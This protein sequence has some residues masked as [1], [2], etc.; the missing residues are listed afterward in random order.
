MEDQ[1]KLR[2][3]IAEQVYHGVSYAMLEEKGE[4]DVRR[5]LA[6]GKY[7]EPGGEEGYDLALSWLA[8]KVTERDEESL[9]ISRRALRNSERATRI[10]ISAIILSII[11]AI[12]NIIEHYST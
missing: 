9:S 7:G 12:L 3:E 2:E 1:D 6:K 8:S 10:A 4:K 5:A 11:M